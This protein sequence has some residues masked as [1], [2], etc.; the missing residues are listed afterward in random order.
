MREFPGHT[1]REKSKVEETDRPT[2][3]KE[4][5]KEKSVKARE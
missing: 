1:E 5:E 2:I 4:R 3:E